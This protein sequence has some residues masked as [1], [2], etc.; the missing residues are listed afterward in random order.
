MLGKYV[1]DLKQNMNISNFLKKNVFIDS[2]NFSFKRYKVYPSAYKKDVSKAISSGDVRIGTGVTKGAGANYYNE[3]DRLEL[4]PSFSIANWDDQAF[5]IHECTHI[6][7]DIQDFG[8]HSGH[9]NE[10]VAY[11]AEAVFL[12]ASGNPA[13]SGHAIRKVSHH[14][15]KKILSGTYSVPI[16]DANDLVKEVAAEPNYS[17]KSVYISNGFNRSLFCSILRSL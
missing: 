6:H 14:I 2:I 5:L 1:P 16:K 17:S 11:L 4:S 9:E 3:F 7:L 10:A 13:L 8:K 15:A 12:E